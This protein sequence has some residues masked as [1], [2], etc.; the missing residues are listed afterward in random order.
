MYD[1]NKIFLETQ[2]RRDMLEKMKKVVAEKMAELKEKKDALA[3]V[4]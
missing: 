2:P 3:V 4:E 1:F